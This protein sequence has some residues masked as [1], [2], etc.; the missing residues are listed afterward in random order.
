MTTHQIS[1]KF[2]AYSS[3][4][5]LHKIRFP[6]LSSQ[7]FD[8]IF[9]V[10]FLFWWKMID[11]W[12][13]LDTS[14]DWKWLIVLT[15]CLMFN[16]V[17]AKSI[18]RTLFRKRFLKIGSF[19]LIAYISTKENVQSFK[20]PFLGY[21]QFIESSQCYGLYLHCYIYSPVKK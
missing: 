9:E 11:L 20:M 3:C 18:C 7:Y 6:V 19:I 10:L 15:Y 2:E 16:V 12:L 13:T 21:E 4:V 14:S 8:R 17:H 5:G 1:M